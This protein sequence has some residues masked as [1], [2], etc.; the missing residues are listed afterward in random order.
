MEVEYQTWI[1]VFEEEFPE[2]ELYY[3]DLDD[4]PRLESGFS[5]SV[6]QVFE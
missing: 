1:N 6:F 5:S 2:A 3:S 4:H